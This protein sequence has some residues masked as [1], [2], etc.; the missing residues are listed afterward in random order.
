VSIDWET[1]FAKFDEKGLAF[2]E[3][4]ADGEISRFCKIIRKPR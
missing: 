1:F 4:T 3:H 2:E